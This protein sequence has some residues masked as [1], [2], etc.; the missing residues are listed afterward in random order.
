[1]ANQ[2]D[3]LDNFEKIREKFEAERRYQP[4]IVID[5]EEGDLDYDD[6]DMQ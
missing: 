5:D 3:T 4:R 6:D 2:D 1:M